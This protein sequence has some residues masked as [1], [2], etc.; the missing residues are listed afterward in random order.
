MEW[1]AAQD[2]ELRKLYE[3]RLS[4]AFIATWMRREGSDVRQRLQ[5]LGLSKSKAAAAAAAAAAALIDPDDEPDEDFP[6]RRGRNKGH[7]LSDEAIGALYRRA[8]RNYA[9][10]LR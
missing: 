4:I 10:P 8:G 1:S 2:A 9:G 5:V 3:K 6:S 7:L